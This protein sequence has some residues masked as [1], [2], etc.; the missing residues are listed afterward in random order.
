LTETPKLCTTYV[1]P[2]QANNSWEYGIVAPL[3]DGRERFIPRGWASK[4]IA[5]ARAADLAATGDEYL[6]SLKRL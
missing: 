6:E 2:A 5:D 1:R 3:G 4:D